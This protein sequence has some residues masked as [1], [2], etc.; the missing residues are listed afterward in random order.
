MKS[1]VVQL[2]EREDQDSPD[3]GRFQNIAS[4]C[5][6]GAAQSQVYGDKKEMYLKKESLP[7]N[8]V[9]FLKPTQIHFLCSVSDAM[10]SEVES[11]FIM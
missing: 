4:P 8:L 3:L 9:C 11:P 1:L 6:H 7:G 10:T 5:T 2:N